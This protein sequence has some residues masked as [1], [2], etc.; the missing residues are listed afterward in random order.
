MHEWI[1]I[2]VFFEWLI[3]VYTALS[4]FYVLVF[5][6][7]GHFRVRK[8]EH[9]PSACIR[10]IGVFIPAFKEDKVIVEVAQEAL[11]QNYPKDRYEVI[12][13]AEWF[14]PDTLDQLRKL[15]VRLIELNNQNP[16]KTLTLKT[17]LNQVPERYDI[18]LILDADNV[19]KPD[20]L[21]KINQAFDVGYRV[22]QGHRTAKNTNTA[23]ARLDAISEEINN[24]IFRKGHRILG[25]SAALIGSGMA[26]D[27]DLFI[28][29]LPWMEAVGG[30]D[31]ELEFAVLKHRIKI[32]YVD[33]AIVLDEKVARSGSF[34]KQRRRWLAAQYYYLRRNMKFAIPAILRGNFDFFDKFI[35]MLLPSRVLMLG[36]TF[37]LFMYNFYFEYIDPA[38]AV[39]GVGALE[40]A[41]V[42]GG[43]LL[44]M[45]IAVPSVFWDRKTL[46]AV[47]AVPRAFVLMLL[48]LLRIKGANKKFLHTEH[49]VVTG[50]KLKNTREAR[51]ERGD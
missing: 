46:R 39:F 33:D 45:V 12:V 32:E 26:F 14:Q 10:K 37:L 24:H 18:V 19:M 36:I 27:Y 11:R 28:D 1:N 42:F 21:M 51:D 7:A 31:K 17:A 25:L 44:A 22:V 3:F 4:A 5:S 8:S 2:V 29:L 40:W 23:L 13:A 47:L 49:E 16:T 9:Q 20:F 38:N 41:I 34:V 30:F 6:I 50:N 35:Q 15:P 43:T 48:A